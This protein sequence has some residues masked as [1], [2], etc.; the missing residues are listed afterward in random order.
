MSA[1][2]RLIMTRIHFVLLLAFALCM[3]E[4]LRICNLLDAWALA[5]FCCLIAEMMAFVLDFENFDG[6]GL[7]DLGLAQVF[8][9]FCF[10][11]V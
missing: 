3:L 1:C 4:A 9:F 2:F 7:F 5:E 10:K 11:D 6:L 8:V